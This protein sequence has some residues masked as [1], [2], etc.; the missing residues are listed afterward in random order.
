MTRL[1]AVLYC[2]RMATDEILHAVT[3][4]SLDARV[5]RDAAEPLRPQRLFDCFRPDGDNLADRVE[6]ELKE[7]IAACSLN[8]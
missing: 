1:L 5:F 7:A 3:I 6:V 4:G 2:A 8:V